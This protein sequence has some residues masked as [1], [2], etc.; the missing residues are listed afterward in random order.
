LLP[1]GHEDE[2]KETKN[3]QI[4]VFL[5]NCV[6]LKV[7]EKKGIKPAIVAG[8]SLG[9][10]SAL[11]ASGALSFPNALNLVKRRGEF[12]QEASQRHLGTMAA[13]IGLEKDKLEQIL[14][15]AERG[16]SLHS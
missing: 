3:T 14:E 2:L 12:M 11:V 4:L 9:E 13:I 15:E 1:R 5:I 6:C 16:E 7:L 10:Y 8:H